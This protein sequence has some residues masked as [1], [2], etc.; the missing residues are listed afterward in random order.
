MPSLI[1]QIS[2]NSYTNIL[3]VQFAKK[4]SVQLNE[5]RRDT[6][7]GTIVYLFTKYLGSGVE[8][9]YTESMAEPVKHTVSRVNLE[10]FLKNAAAQL[11]LP[12]DDHWVLS[13]VKNWKDKKADKPLLND[14]ITAAFAEIIAKSTITPDMVQSF[15]SGEICMES[16]PCQHNC[17][18]ILKDHRET[19]QTLSAPKICLLIDMLGREKITFAGHFVRSCEEVAVDILSKHFA[20]ENIVP[21]MVKTLEIQPYI[22]KTCPPQYAAKVILPDGKEKRITLFEEDM[23]VLIRA[24]PEDRISGLDAHPNLNS[25]AKA[26]EILTRIFAQ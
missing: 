2:S 20:E 24:I 5:I 16:H 6:W 19:M 15:D 23:S 9:L 12:V 26:V 18:I 3:E 22:L 8:T 17:K 1:K 4:N 13:K 14:L 10:K 21:S 25:K 7:I 11:H